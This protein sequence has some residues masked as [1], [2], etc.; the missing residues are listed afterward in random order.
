MGCGFFGNVFVGMLWE[1]WGGGG[2]ADFSP[3]LYSVWLGLR[4]GLTSLPVVNGLVL[5]VGWGLTSLPVVYGL[6][7]G[8]GWGLTSLPVV[9][10]LVLGFRWRLT[11]LPLCTVY[12]SALLSHS[13]HGGGFSESAKIGSGFDPENG[14]LVSHMQH[15]HSFLLMTSL[16][17]PTFTHFL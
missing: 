15:T 13:L 9:Y 5:G 4:V 3:S 11:S 10:G 8:V 1:G 12:G 2:G 17:S 14:T 7:L 16:P 6:V